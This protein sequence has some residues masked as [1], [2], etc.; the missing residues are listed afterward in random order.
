M[1]GFG[2][3]ALSLPDDL[4]VRRRPEFE[5]VVR[6]LRSDHGRRVM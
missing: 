2:R 3:G 5:Q 1:Y 4:E 6:R